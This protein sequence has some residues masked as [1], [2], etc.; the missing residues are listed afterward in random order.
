V[1][2]LVCPVCGAEC[3]FREIAS[4]ERE[5]RELWPARDG[6]VSVARFQ[7]RGAVR[8]RTFSMLPYQLVP[9]HRYT[10]Q[11]MILTVLLWREYWKDPAEPGTA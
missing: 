11:S 8:Y 7:C 2:G 5:V 3:G 1:I 4:Y 6:V 9:Y 10:L